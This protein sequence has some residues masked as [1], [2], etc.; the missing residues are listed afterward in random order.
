MYSEIKD[1]LKNVANVKIHKYLISEK[2]KNLT[3]IYTVRTR[4]KIKMIRKTRKLLLS[5]ISPRKN[6]HLKVLALSK[7][8]SLSMA[9]LAYY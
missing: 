6:S 5:S 3:P 7:V 9:Q 8:K 4:D 1:V 2:R